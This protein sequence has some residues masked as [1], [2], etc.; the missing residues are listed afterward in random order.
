MFLTF[1][2]FCVGAVQE[3]KVVIGGLVSPLLLRPLGILVV[4]DCRKL[5]LCLK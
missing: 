1:L 5:H 4:I 2:T 3:L